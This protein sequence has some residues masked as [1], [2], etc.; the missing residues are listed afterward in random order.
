MLKHFNTGKYL[1]IDPKEGMPELAGRVSD[2]S[3]FVF[4]PVNGTNKDLNKYSTGTVFK[5][6]CSVDGQDE[7][8]DYLRVMNTRHPDFKEQ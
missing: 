2:S 1:Y 4:E 6:R 8:A 3:E 7:E 5:V